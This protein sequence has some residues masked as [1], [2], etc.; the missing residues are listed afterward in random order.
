MQAAEVFLF[1]RIRSA[2]PNCPPL[3]SLDEHTELRALGIDS[4]ELVG[5]LIDLEQR[6]DLD[7]AAMHQ[8]LHRGCTLG[9]LRTMC[10]G[11]T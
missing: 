4:M 5:L 6:F 2:A 1:D 8:H 3:H 9:S 7:L 11:T 10:C